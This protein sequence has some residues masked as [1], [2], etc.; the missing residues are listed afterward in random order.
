MCETSCFV[1]A[2]TLSGS[3]CGQQWTGVDPGQALDDPKRLTALKET[4]LMDSPI[5]ASFDRFTR[6]VSMALRCEVSIMSLVDTDR[7]FF[8][9]ATGLPEPYRTLRQTPLSH[10][11]CQHVVTSGKLLR[12]TDARLDPLVRE[13]GAV[14]DLGVQAYLGVPIVTDSGFVLG[15]FCAISGHAREWSEQDLAIL[16]SINQAVLNE[17]RLRKGATALRADMRNLLLTEKQRDEVLHLLVHDMRTLLAAVITSLELFE[18]SAEMN[19]ENKEMFEIAQHGGE[20]LLGML[21]DM[22]EVNRIESSELSQKPFSVSNLLRYVFQLTKPLADKAGH[23]LTVVYPVADFQ[24]MAEEALLS[25]VLM[26]LTA[27]AVKYCPRG[28]KIALRAEKNPAGSGGG[29]RFSVSDNGPGVPD[30]DKAQI[31]GRY[32]KGTARGESGSSFGLGLRFCK[33]TVEAHGGSIVVR[34]VPGGGSD[35]FFGIPDLSALP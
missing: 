5:E 17:I 4:G 32:Q 7:Q 2:S 26:N 13:N 9:S 16:E 14:S 25:R 22:L 18:G 23:D 29:C 20:Q 30:G 6:L 31:F 35:F 12:V 34:D 11:F 33:L 21:T 1:M 24:L 8:K 10:S 27:N 15:S 19:A 3:L 28:S